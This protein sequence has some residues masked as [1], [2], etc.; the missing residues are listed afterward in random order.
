MRSSERENNLALGRVDWVTVAVYAA[1]VLMGWLNIY[2]AVYDDAHASIFDIGQRYGMQ[3]VWIGISAFIALSILLIDDKYY[4]V[5]AYPL[6]WLSLLLLIGVLFFGKEVN[7]AKSWI[8]IGPVALQPTEFVKFTTAL[9][10][11]RY[12]SS[13][14][15]DIHRF[16]DLLRVGAILG[17]PVA[18]VMLQNDTGSA[19][20]YGSFLFMLFRE[21][22][23]GWVYVALFLVISLFVLSF[24]LEPT[25]LL[26]V[27][28]LVCVA[29]EAATNGLWRSKAIYLAGLAL[30]AILIYAGASLAGV[31]IGWYAAILSA[32]VLSSAAVAVY[33]YRYK[34]R[35]TLTFVLLF[36]GSLVFTRTI[37]YVFHNVMQIHQQK[38]ILDLLGLESDLK[39]WGYNVNQ[40]KIAIGSGG[41]SGKGFLEGT[42]TKFNFV[43]LHRRRGMG[44]SGQPDRRRAV[45][46]PDPASDPHGRAPDGTVRKDLLL[47]RSVDLPVPRRGQHR[48]DDR[49]HAGDRHTFAFL[50]LRRLV[51]DRVHGP[52]VR[53]RPPRRG[54]AGAVDM[55]HEHRNT[56][57][58][59]RNL[60]VLTGGPGG[61]KSTVLDILDGMGYHTVR[62][63]GRKIIRSQAETGGNA[64]PWADTARYAR[65][66]SL[67]S[68]NDFEK[69][70]DLGEPCFFDRGI[71]D[72]W[73]Y[74]RLIG[75]PVF[76]ELKNAAEKC[77]YNER[78][79]LFPFWEEIYVNDSERKQSPDEARE[80]CRV[81]KDTYE[82]LGYRTITVPF[83]PPGE[84]ARWMIDR[85]GKTP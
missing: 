70:A 27:L 28:I 16:G 54:E 74:C 8:M 12:M 34:I 57:M 32:V 81:L 68:R 45:R 22:F 55:I 35:N 4:H 3:M 76:R 36:F 78:V 67:Q 17:L 14:T 30:G 46:D 40:S 24:L 50:Q 61:G 60:Y 41:F 66:M 26:I 23:N 10:L 33:A 39:H 15:F 44:L 80:T 5:L 21:G 65:L 13:Y 1:L 84:R 79:F 72:V 64:V 77:L 42:Q 2:A 82:R 38:R 59:N 29:G 37:D 6:Y 52:A 69:Y 20:V 9:A 62:E 73:G 47:L 48:H 11:A 31:P 51:A 85:I 56:R 18:I 83:L 43:L 58:R 71:V 63:A 75:L 7:G 19:L 53:S 25:M 49:D